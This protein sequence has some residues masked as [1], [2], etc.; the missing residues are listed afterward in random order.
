MVV[1]IVPYKVAPRINSFIT[2]GDRR[3]TSIYNYSLDQL[4]QTRHIPKRMKS[5]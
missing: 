4:K 5:R 3:A 2:L 1:P